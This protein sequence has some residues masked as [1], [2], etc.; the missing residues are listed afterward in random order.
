MKKI[1]IA[2]TILL[3]SHSH[4]AS[5][6]YRC[7][8]RSYRVNLTIDGSSTLM[9]LYDYYGVLGFGYV[10]WI[11]TKKDE[12]IFHFNLS[13]EGPAKLFFK[14][15]SIEALPLKMTGWIEAN[16]RGFLLWDA[17]KCHKI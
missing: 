17:L 9:W 4:A 3:S 16:A 14:S 1:L 5:A 12:K 7:E 10:N 6:D 8:V 15:S 2:M 13:N 11:E